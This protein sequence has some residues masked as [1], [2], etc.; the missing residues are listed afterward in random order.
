MDHAI[1][2]G[3]VMGLIDEKYVKLHPYFRVSIGDVG[4]HVRSLEYFYDFFQRE[5]ETK[6][7]VNKD[8]YKV[9]INY[10]MHRAESKI[11]DE[12]GLGPFSRWCGTSREGGIFFLLL[13]FLRFVF[14]F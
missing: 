9:E 11:S 13:F 3:K 12:Y 14:L 5:M 2:I 7:P 6:D 8:P 4:G 1:E 10:V